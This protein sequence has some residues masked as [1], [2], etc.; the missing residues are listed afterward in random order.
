MT[1]PVDGSWITEG[2][3]LALQAT[4]EDADLSS[5]TIWRSDLDRAPG[6]C[7]TLNV[8]LTAGNHQISASITEVAPFVWTKKPSSLSGLKAMVYAARVKGD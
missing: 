6:N 8:I 2:D 7:A 4:A 3:S 1:S 5:V